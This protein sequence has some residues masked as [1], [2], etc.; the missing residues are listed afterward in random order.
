MKIRVTAVSYLN[1]KP[2][3]F[4]IEHSDLINEI[5]LSLDIPSEGARKLIEG[6]ADIGLIP[7]AAI[8]QIN[9]ARVVTDYC[10]GTDGEVKTVCIFSEVPI[11]EI[12]EI[13][14]DYQSRTSVELSKILLRN[15]FKIEVKQIIAAPGFESEIKNQTAGLVIGDRAIEM[16]DRFPFVYDLGL[17][18]KKFTGLPFVFAAW[19]TNQNIPDSFI[20]RLNSALRFGIHHIPK[21]AEEYA[22]FYPSGF[23]V[24]E[25]FKKNISYQLD[26]RKK[27]GMSKFLEMIKSTRGGS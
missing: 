13:Y 1:T 22:A 14:L 26:D 8:P 12:E 27:E 19:V 2:F 3:L 15:H 25:Y 23:D 20:N 4:G 21:V 10:I 6:T 16:L 9:D 7:V 5:E 24:K 17:E 18:W 11:N